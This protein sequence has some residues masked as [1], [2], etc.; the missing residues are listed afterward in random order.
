MK[1]LM[2]MIENR[3][4][5]H[6]QSKRIAE[7]AEKSEFM[8]AISSYTGEMTEIY[9]EL[10]WPYRTVLL[11]FIIVHFCFYVFVKLEKIFRR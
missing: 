5:L 4:L 7:R 8:P 3:R 10:A 11:V 9:R 2:R 1:D 6:E